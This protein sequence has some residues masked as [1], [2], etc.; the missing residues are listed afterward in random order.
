MK[1]ALD[2]NVLISGMLNPFGPPGKIVDFLKTDILQL[3]VDDRIIAEYIDVLNRDYFLK[4][5]SESDREDIIDYL[6][7]NSYY[8]SS[9]VVIKDMPD[10]GDM[11]FIEMAITEGVP[12]ITGNIKH[13]PVQLR[14]G[15]I[16]ISPAQFLEK[17]F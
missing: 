7:K 2:T 15:C 13:F 3:V 9:N 12:L 17:Y 16:V 1:I 6:S 8:S 14:K 11:P 5:F 10:E 4:Y